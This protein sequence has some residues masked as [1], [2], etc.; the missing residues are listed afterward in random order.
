M[1]DLT[2]LRLAARAI[3]DETLRAVD[4]AAAVTRTVRVDKSSLFVGK[5]PFKI[6]AGGVYSVAIG[7]AAYGMAG[8]FEAAIGERFTAGVISSSPPPPNAAHELSGRWQ[9]FAG[10]HPLP[11]DASELAARAACSLLERAN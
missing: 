2:Q 3:F 1:T 7:K 9:K 10:G 8:A 6:P 4:P 5:R 11:N